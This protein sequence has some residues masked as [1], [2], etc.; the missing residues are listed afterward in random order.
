MDRIYGSGLVKWKDGK[1]ISH[2]TK[3]DGL[4]SNYVNALD[5]DDKGNIVIGT[6][7]G[8]SI[9][10]GEEFKNYDFRSGIGNGFITDVKAIGKTIWIG[11]GTFSG[12]GNWMTIG[13][14]SL[15]SMVINLNPLTFQNSPI[16]I[17]EH[18]VNSIE[19]DKNGN[20]WIGT[21][22]GLLKYDGS[23]FT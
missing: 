7:S 15:Y 2:Y 17:I 4:P 12:V 20:V 1:V 18:H 3:K 8:L 13:G 5:E 11:C 22:G 9:F 6:N 14:G 10:N 21:L 16:L 23:Q 19:K